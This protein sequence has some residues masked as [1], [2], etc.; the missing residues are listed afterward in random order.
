MVRILFSQHLGAKSCRKEMKADRICRDF[1]GLLKRNQKIRDAM[2]NEKAKSQKDTHSV[3]AAA[4]PQGRQHSHQ[5]DPWM[6]RARRS[7][8]TPVLSRPQLKVNLRLS[9]HTMGSLM[10]HV[11]RQ[12]RSP[13]SC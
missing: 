10:T 11:S 13:Y 6:I 1:A 9:V 7:T 8:A 4:Q 3:I 5:S 12:G 2:I